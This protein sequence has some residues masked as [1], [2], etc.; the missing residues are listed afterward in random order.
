MWKL[1]GLLG[2][3]TKI[4]QPHHS[5]GLVVPRRSTHGIPTWLESVAE[6]APLEALGEVQE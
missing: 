5:V 1:L 6:L 4:L 3:S 2:C